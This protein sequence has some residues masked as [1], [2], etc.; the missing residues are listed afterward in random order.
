MNDG[1]PD[2]GAE[3]EQPSQELR[4]DLAKQQFRKG[5]RGTE[6]RPPMQVRLARPA[7]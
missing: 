3:I 4:L 2:P 6:L 7:I 1:Q 5:R